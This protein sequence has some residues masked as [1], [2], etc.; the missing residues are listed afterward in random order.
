MKPLKEGS[1]IWF[2]VWQNE[3]GWSYRIEKRGNRWTAWDAHGFRT[4]EAAEA[5]M[6]EKLKAIA[7]VV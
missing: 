1:D 4:K 7:K 2:D 3:D 5:I 6:N